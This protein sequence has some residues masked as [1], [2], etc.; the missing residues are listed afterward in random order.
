MASYWPI[1][2]GALIVLFTLRETFQDLFHPSQ[3]G[4]LSDFIARRTFAVFRRFPRLLPNAGPLSVVI[5]VF[6]WVLLICFGFALIYWP[7]P[8]RGF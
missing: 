1:I 3:S 6:V 2:P 5:V 7:L 4:T 8:P